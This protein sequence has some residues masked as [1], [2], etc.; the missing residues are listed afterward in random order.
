MTRLSPRVSPRRVIR[1]VT[2]AVF[3]F[4]SGCRTPVA[5]PLP[6]AP[7]TTGPT[8]ITSPNTSTVAALP[9]TEGEPEGTTT[10]VKDLFA[11][12]FADPG[13][14][15]FERARAA[16]VA[17][18]EY[19]P[20]SADLDDIGELVEQEKFDEAKTAIAKSERNL[21]LS[22]LFHWHATVVADKT[23]QDNEA[24]A[25]FKKQQACLTGILATGDGSEERP[26]LVTRVSDEYDVLRHLKQRSASQGLM[27][28]G[29]KRFDVLDTTDGQEIWFDVTD[30]FQT[31]AKK[32][33]RA[34]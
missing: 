11:T 21:L 17:S 24:V 27:R 29:E 4:A 3:L 25:E 1:F 6:A 16:L 33:N 20:Y 28:S 5:T 15:S 9:A 19:D 26:Y 23:G 31:I 30:A 14:E 32:I 13:R 22:P 2:A 18:T 7:L 10:D 8:P 12:F 34:K